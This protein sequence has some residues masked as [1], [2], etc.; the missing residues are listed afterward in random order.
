MKL[1]LTLLA[2]A[3]FAAPVFAATHT[4]VIDADSYGGFGGT[5]TFDDH[6]YVGPTGVGAL[7]FEVTSTVT[8]ITGFDASRVGQVQNVV[9]KDPDWVTSDPLHNVYNDRTNALLPNANMDGTVNF[10]QWGYTT[11]G[12]STFNKMTI[13][14]AGNYHVA[15]NDMSFQ[16]YDVFQYNNG[17][18]VQT[19]DTKINF[20]PYAVSDA[21]G[22]CGSVLATNPDA[23]ETMAGQVTFDFAFDVFREGTIGG[24]PTP[25]STEIVPGFVMRSY[26]SYEVNVDGGQVYSGSAVVNNTDPTTGLPSEAWRNQVSFLG[27]GVIPNGVWVFNDGTPDVTLA[28]DQSVT[29]TEAAGQVRESDGATWHANSFAGYAFLLRADGTRMLTEV[30]GVAYDPAAGY[31]GDRAAWTDY[32][33]PAA[34]PEAETYAMMLAGLG[35]VGFMVRRRRRPIGAV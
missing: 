20:Q 30:G 34:V 1:K 23:L 7:D 19:I 28:E 22:W 24:T 16:Y 4:T 18:S 31:T 5:I 11:V 29:G 8:G 9:T 35:L 13:D 27:A 10:Y 15:R 26:G 32:P 3:L 6:G 21:K 17:S 12:G 14:T 2:S 25:M 33:A